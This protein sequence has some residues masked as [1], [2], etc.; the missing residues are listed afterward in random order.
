M[1]YC[2]LEARVIARVFL[3]LLL[4]L[5]LHCCSLFC[6]ILDCA[7]FSTNHQKE[8]NRRSFWGQFLRFFILYY[9]L[10]SAV[11]EAVCSREID[12]EVPRIRSCGSREKGRD[13]RR[14]L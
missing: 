4:V 13:E 5:S 11:S 3:L 8:E 14:V 12:G 1:S 7:R 6:S 9:G 2:I 10:V